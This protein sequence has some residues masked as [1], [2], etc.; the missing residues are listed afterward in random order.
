MRTLFFSTEV[1]LFIL[2]ETRFLSSGPALQSIKVFTGQAAVQCRTH[3]CISAYAT[4]HTARQSS[5]TA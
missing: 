2:V 4:N 5:V 3:A 1:Q